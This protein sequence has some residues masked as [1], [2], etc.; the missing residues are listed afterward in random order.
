M[1]LPQLCGVAADLIAAVQG[2]CQPEIG[3]L[4]IEKRLDDCAHAWVAHLPK[5]LVLPE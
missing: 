2:A 3:P 5:T 1:T 4:E